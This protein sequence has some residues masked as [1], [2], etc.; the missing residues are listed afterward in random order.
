MGDKQGGGVQFLL[1]PFDESHNLR[2]N[3][4]VQGGGRFVGDENFGIADQGHGDHHPLSHSPRE[5]KGKLVDTF[6]RTGN[7]HL[8]QHVDGPRA[9]RPF[10]EGLMLPDRLHQ[11]VPDP[12]HRTERRHRLLENH[13]DFSAPQMEQLLIVIR[14]RSDIHRRG[15]GPVSLPR[16]H[17][18]NA[19][20]GD[21]ARRLDQPQ[22]GIAGHGLAAARFANKSQNPTAP[23]MKRHS[24]H[25]PDCPL[26][27]VEHHP[28]V[29]HFQDICVR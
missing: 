20:A 21:L 23:H 11:L 9:R 10:V 5:F 1:Q 2:L 4:H 12:V 8:A 17:E 26:L 6:F 28:Q 16:G 15:S 18:T 24:V 22:Q 19:A 14:Q 13:A 25:R 3:G 29:L 7:P 27:S